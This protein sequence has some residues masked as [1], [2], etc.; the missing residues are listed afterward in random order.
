MDTYAN[1]PYIAP[2][3]PHL[4]LGELRYEPVTALRADSDGYR[5]LQRIAA[6]ARRS[7]HQE[8]GC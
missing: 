6:Q 5:D 1:P 7:W 2:D 4:T 8:A 3:D